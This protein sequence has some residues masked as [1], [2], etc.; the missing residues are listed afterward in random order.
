MGP[1]KTAADIINRTNET[2]D[3]TPE[4]QK[5]IYAASSSSKLSP[6]C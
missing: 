4:A 3:K 5:K 2:W 6:L 1:F